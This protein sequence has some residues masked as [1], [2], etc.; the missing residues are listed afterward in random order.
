MR[1]K[2]CIT[3]LPKNA[4]GAN[5]TAW[6]ER[7]HY[8]PDRLLSL[9]MDAYMSRK[10]I[11]K[12]ESKYWNDIVNGYVVVFHLKKLNVRNVM[13]M[14]A[15]YGGYLSILFAYFPFVFT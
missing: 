11:Y 1:Q 13:D 15:G 7:L 12:T 9:K 10:D 2:A 3:R 6:P 8:P 4:Y 14:R 5:V